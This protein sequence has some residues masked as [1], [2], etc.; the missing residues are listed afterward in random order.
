MVRA[1]EIYGKYENKDSPYIWTVGLGKISS[2]SSYPGGGWEFA[3]FRFKGTPEKK[4][5]TCQL[6][7]DIDFS[8]SRKVTYA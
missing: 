4:H 5:E 6:V 8:A 7:N 2:S 3:S 1:I